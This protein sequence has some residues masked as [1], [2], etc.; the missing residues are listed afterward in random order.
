M[1][2]EQA[3]QNIRAEWRSLIRGITEPAKQSVNGETS[4]VCPLCGHGTHGDGMTKNPKSTDGNSLKC[5]G[6][7]YTGDIIDLYQKVKGV[8]YNEALADL[9]GQLGITIE[10]TAL[11]HPPIKTD[12]AK[13]MQTPSQTED[14]TAYYKKAMAAFKGSPAQ[15]YLKSRG[16]GE[17]TAVKFWLGYEPEFKTRE[18]DEKGQQSYATWRALIIPTGKGNYIIRNI[19]EPKGDVKKNRYRKKGA[20]IIFNSKALY[21]ATKPIF[22]VEGEMDALS[23]IEAGGEAVGL[24][25]TS[26]YKQL[27]KML[28]EKPATQTLVL[29][30]DADEE[31]QKTEEALAQELTQ[32]KAPFYHY[33]PY[34]TAKDANEALTMDRDSFLAEVKAGEQAEAAELEAIAEAEKEEYLKTSAAEEL[35]NFI[36]KVKESANTPAISTGFKNLDSVLDG[37]LYAGLYIIG[38]ISSLGKTTLAL[39]MIDQ[40]AQQGQDCLVFSL[41]MARSELIAKSLS[42]HTFLSAENRKD[43]KT[44]RGILAGARYDKYSQT[45]KGLINKAIGQYKEY[46]QHIFIQEGIGD[47]GIEQVKETVKQHIEITGNHP[48]VLIDYIQILAPYDMRSSDKQNT[49]KATLELKRLSRDYK[50]PVIGISSFNR[51]NYKEP[52]NMGAF[53]ESGAIEYS[54]DVLIGLQ[55]AGMDYQEGEADSARQKRIRELI[56]RMEESAK[57]GDA[58]RIQ[59]KVLKYRNGSRGQALFDFYAM[60]NCFKDYEPDFEPAKK[61]P[62]KGK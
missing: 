14:N 52:V 42:R 11:V 33:S 40:L 24:G 35:K 9:S 17:D 31:G 30:L 10:K 34:G 22:V 15:E 54:A 4:Y 5:F 49:D 27:V 28:M 36:G 16:I 20:S 48:V 56:K 57:D 41:E 51:D 47:I 46:A 43:A 19:D 6:C 7:G 2:R 60:F 39:Q 53:K 61:N 21:S 44:T 13:P 26:N 32:I 55:Y 12:P 50:I 59:A 62:F 29:A 8:D 23:I 45:E 25:S 18:T 38:A 1:D 3:R 37:G 58:Q